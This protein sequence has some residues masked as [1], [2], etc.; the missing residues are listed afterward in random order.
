MLYNCKPYK[1]YQHWRYF[2]KMANITDM[3]DIVIQ[4]IPIDYKILDLGYHSELVTNL[5]W[6]YRQRTK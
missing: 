5:L 3:Q 1:K 2:P 6:K 4:P